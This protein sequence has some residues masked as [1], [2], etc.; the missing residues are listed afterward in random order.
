MHSHVEHHDGFGGE[1]FIRFSPHVDLL[2][3]HTASQTWC[4]AGSRNPKADFISHL[5]AFH[6][7]P[8]SALLSYPPSS[9]TSQYHPSKSGAG[10]CTASVSLMLH[11]FTAARLRDT[12]IKKHTRCFQQSAFLWFPR[13]NSRFE[14]VLGCS[15]S[16]QSVTSQTEP[17][18]A[19]VITPT[20][21]PGNLHNHSRTTYGNMGKKKTLACY[22]G[23][24]TRF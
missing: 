5:R 6:V 8:A 17:D 12:Q 20:I 3:T 13:I 23:V 16:C 24:S 4:T 19:D 14:V 15:V 2:P 10:A 21:W 7:A 18:D 22:D 1:E 9:A 11:G